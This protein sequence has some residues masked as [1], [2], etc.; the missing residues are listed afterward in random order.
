M[1]RS[2]VYKNL[3][4]SLLNKRLIAIFKNNLIFLSSFDRE[5]YL[6]DIWTND[7]NVETAAVAENNSRAVGNP[8]VGIDYLN[9]AKFKWTSSRISVSIRL[10]MRQRTCEFFMV[11][12]IGG[13]KRGISSEP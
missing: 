2:A 3:Y 11:E 4:L 1:R 12:R 10:E 7:P 5:W 6:S 9:N 8:K 13:G